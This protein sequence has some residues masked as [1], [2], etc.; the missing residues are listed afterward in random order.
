MKNGECL[1]RALDVT[2]REPN[3]AK[4]ICEFFVR[5]SERVQRI[6]G[7]RLPRAFGV[8]AQA[9]PVIAW[10]SKL[11]LLVPDDRCLL[12]ASERE[13]VNGV[14]GFVPAADQAHETPADEA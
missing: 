6:F 2:L 1:L 13:R 3:V 11:H 4:V 10:C 8:D 7:R 12:E 9:D 5:A 14:Q